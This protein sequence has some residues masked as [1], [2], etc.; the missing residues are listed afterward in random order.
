MTEN[1]KKDISFELAYSTDSGSGSL[2]INMR[3]FF[4]N[5]NRNAIR[6]MID[7]VNTYGDL[8][9]LV[10][11][12]NTIDEAQRELNED[13]EAF[14]SHIGELETIL[15][16]Y[17]DQYSTYRHAKTAAENSMRQLSGKF[18]Y[19]QELLTKRIAAASLK[20]ERKRK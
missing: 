4:L 3:G 14:E 1:G 10:V 15:N 12:S 17:A 18:D 7:T 9:A 11:L 8:T 6:K 20:D 13:I 5:S 2:T 19:A 16:R